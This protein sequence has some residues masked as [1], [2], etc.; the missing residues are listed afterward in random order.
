LKAFDKNVETLEGHEMDLKKD[1]ELCSIFAMSNVVI[2]KTKVF[3]L[4]VIYYY[5][6]LIS[7]EDILLPNS[8]SCRYH[9]VIEHLQSSP[10][11]LHR[12]FSHISV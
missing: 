9:P 7:Q 3:I 12:E 10:I 8:S 4:K 11:L 2:I 1:R 6:Y 5:P